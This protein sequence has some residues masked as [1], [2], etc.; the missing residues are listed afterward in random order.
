MHDQ[1]FSERIMR[2][3]LELRAKVPADGS[4]SYGDWHENS[5]E[6][7]AADRYNRA[8]NQRPAAVSW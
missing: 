6:T 3:E 1:R 5:R 7:R 8:Q 2:R 4:V